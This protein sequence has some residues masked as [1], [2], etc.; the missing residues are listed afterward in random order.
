MRTT[1][2]DLTVD[3][4]EP[5]ITDADLAAC[6]DCGFSAGPCPTQPPIC[7]HIF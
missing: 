3:V 7:G 2:L 5:V 4:C 1:D 6:A